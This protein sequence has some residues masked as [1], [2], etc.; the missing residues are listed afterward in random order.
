MREAAIVLGSA[1]LL[2]API[3]EAAPLTASLEL[4]HPAQAL[5]AVVASATEGALD[6][7]HAGQVAI[8]FE[9]GSGWIVT[10]TLQYAGAQGVTE[11]FTQTSSANDTFDLDAGE[12]R[13]LDCAEAC[14]ALLLASG[15]GVLRLAGEAGGEVARLREARV[16][17]FGSK[18]GQVEDGFFFV[19]ATGAS[20]IGAGGLALAGAEA[21]AEGV[22][23]LFLQNGSIEAAT[24]SGAQTL[25][26]RR[27]SE[28]TM[29]PAGLRTGREDH[30]RFLV[31][32][33]EGA[34]LLPMEAAG[35][36]LFAARPALDVAGTV[37]STSASGV[38]EVAGERRTLHHEAFLAEGRFLAE[39]LPGDGASPAPLLRSDGDLRL[40]GEM[41][42]LIV[43]TTPVEASTGGA[44]V[45]VAVGA[46]LAALVLGVLAWKLGL[47]PLYTRLEPTTLLRNPNR[48]LVADAIA[49]RPGS[50]VADLV[51]ELRMAEVVVRHHLGILEQH[52]LAV[53]RTNGRFRGYFPVGMASAQDAIVTLLLRDATRRRVAE[54][55]ANAATPL[56]QAEIAALAGISARLA[57]Y[58]VG[59]LERD[60][61]V[62]SEGSQPRRYAASSG[63][64]VVIRR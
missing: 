20:V 14:T 11:V 6:V 40:A 36:T 50:T 30:A 28:P 61:L 5:G 17:A 56:S 42:T 51:R 29:G 10:R 33:L 54:T 57:S 47:L 4:D 60:G 38:I 34:R 32:H 39:P 25:D 53:A 58:H 24:A 13:G 22:L 43:G 15:E 64:G 26:A 59:R 23:T 63:L 19:A 7:T 12:L 8:A 3:A 27:T 31:L 9:R 52:G 18:Q 44:T 46:T 41:E 55:I 21:S 45:A 1:L 16:F 37:S 48:R 2:L 62:A 35:A 49:A